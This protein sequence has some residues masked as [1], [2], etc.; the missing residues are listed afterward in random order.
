MLRRSPSPRVFPLRRRLAR[1]VKKPAIAVRLFRARFRVAR[2]LAEAEPPERPLFAALLKTLR[3]ESTAEE[4]AWMRRI[5]GLLRPARSSDETVERLLYL[6]EPATPDEA[7]VVSGRLG[8]WCRGGTRHRFWGRLLL[9]LVRELRPGSCLELGT[10]FGM[11]A[12]YQA[13]GLALNGA[14]TLVSLE[15]DPAA[16]DRARQHA[17]TLGLRNLQVVVGRFDDTLDAVLAE[18]A[19][20]DF[21]F[22]DADKREGQMAAYVDRVLPYLAPRAVVV[23][24]DIHWSDGMERS[25]RRVEADP[26]IAVS[27]DLLGYGLCLVDPELPGKRAYSIPIG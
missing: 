13:A 25:W 18:R 17:E 26:R 24:D 21:F 14:G 8:D 10:A 5:E 12:M 27:I 15:G 6:G 20:I 16:A 7:R 1:E 9:N 11:T 23:M 22:Y 3:L 2:L 19:P 4:R